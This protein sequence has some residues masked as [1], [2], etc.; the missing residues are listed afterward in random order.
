M[1]GGIVLNGRDR[2]AS[3]SSSMPLLVFASLWGLISVFRRRP[4]G[5]S[6]GLRVILLAAI[7][8]CGAVMIFGWIFDRFEADFLPFLIL[9]SAVGMVDVWRRFE[10]SRR[11]HRYFALAIVT[12]LGV[13]GIAANL[14][15]AT[16]PQGEWLGNQVLHYVQVQK[17]I[18]DVTGDPLAVL[19]SLL[20]C[21]H[22]PENH[23]QCAEFRDGDRCGAPTDTVGNF[24]LVT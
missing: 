10:V 8:G 17:S 16:T 12:A 23:H 21:S 22:Q 3:V 7:T 20:S 13:F 18:S 24:V 19:V 11:T 4:V 5:R 1:V 6:N 2:V 15:I 9:A 14:G